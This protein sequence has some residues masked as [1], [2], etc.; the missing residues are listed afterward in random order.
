MGVYKLLIH[1]S[2]TDVINFKWLN[3]CIRDTTLN[4]RNSQPDAKISMNGTIHAMALSPCERFIYISCYPFDKQSLEISCINLANLDFVGRIINF[5]T[6]SVSV[7]GMSDM[8]PAMS[9]CNNYI[10]INGNGLLSGVLIERHYGVPIAAFPCSEYFNGLNA[11]SG[12]SL[13]SSSYEFWCGGEDG[14]VGT[15]LPIVDV[16]R[17]R[18]SKRKMRETLKN[19]IINQVQDREILFRLS[20]WTKT[21]SDISQHPLLETPEIL[22]R[23]GLA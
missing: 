11:K 21:A 20:R 10:A 3:F 15:P 5:P 4:N 7:P 22:R 14:D 6:P 9:V 23:L 19:P 13:V 17:I 16:F 12:G 2:T 1:S 18:L 8:E